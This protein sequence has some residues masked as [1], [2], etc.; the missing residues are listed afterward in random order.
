MPYKIKLEVEFEFGEIV[1]HKTDTIDHMPHIV[2]G[3]LIQNNNVR[4]ECMYK[5][6]A[7]YYYA[8]ELSR[9]PV[10]SQVAK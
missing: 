1:Y 4:Y 9:I 3:V 6:R 10:Y 8:T 2:T 7:C 5:D